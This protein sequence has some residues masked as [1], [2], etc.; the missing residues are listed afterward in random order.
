MTTCMTKRSLAP[1][2]EAE[3]ISLYL[4]GL[5][6]L[7]VGKQFGV[8]LS[9]IRL[10]LIRHEIPRRKSFPKLSESQIDEIALRYSQGELL[11]PLAQE[12]AVS[13]TTLRNQLRGHNAFIERR[14]FQGPNSW[15]FKGTG[16]T[17]NGYVEIWLDPSDPMAIM[18]NYRGYVR[19]HRLTVARYLG[20]PL[21]EAE[22]VHHID[23]IR[24]NNHISNLQ[25]RQGA[26]GSGQVW[27]CHDCG[28]TDVR[29]V[30]LLGSGGA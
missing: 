18:R 19:E 21:R 9:T 29:A 28:S 4:G 16:I 15:L 20:R 2:Q 26:H 14:K 27:R 13:P 1:D 12:Y 25:L 10:T 24:T 23:G 8:E 5:T 6:L 3:A 7:E 17:S 11:V 30:P 22:T